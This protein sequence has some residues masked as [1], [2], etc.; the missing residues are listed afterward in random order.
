MSPSKL[1]M[2][3]HLIVFLPSHI[4]HPPCFSPPSSP[5]HLG[6]TVI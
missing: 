5:P 3:M 1:F 4:M 2:N 6:V